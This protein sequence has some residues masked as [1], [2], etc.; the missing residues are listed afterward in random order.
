MNK[1]GQGLH[2]VADVNQASAL[3]AAVITNGGMQFFYPPNKGPSLVLIT[4]S[5][6]NAALIAKDA[7][8]KEGVKN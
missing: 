7:A 8:E 4:L 3:A 6:L 2:G 1:H 5:K